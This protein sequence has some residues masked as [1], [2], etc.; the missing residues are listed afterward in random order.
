MKNNRAPLLLLVLA[1]VTAAYWNHFGNAFHFD[2]SHTI[3]ENAY[4]RDIRNIP[5]F[6]TDATRFSVLPA[7][8]SYRPV[9]TATLAIDYWLNYRLPI[10]G[11]HQFWFHLSTF[12][13]FLTQLIA[14]YVLFSKTM[15][16]VRPSSN[17]AYVAL[18]ATAWYGLHPAN[19]ETVNYII[20]RGDV[21][22]T[23]GV[24]V[25]LALFARFPRWRKTGLYL[26]P[27]AVAL[28]AK[29]PALVFPL[30]LSL[31]VWYFEETSSPKRL[32]NVL[33]QSWPAWVLAIALAWLQ[34][35]LTPKTFAPTGTSN[36]DYLITQPYVWL[37]YFKNFV[38]PLHLSADTELGAFHS[39]NS[40]VLTGFLFVATISVIV[41][42]TARRPRL[43]PISFGVA[44]FIVALLPTSVYSLSDAENDH[45]MYFAFVGLVLA[46]SWAAALAIETLSDRKE[47]SPAA[48]FPL[49]AVVPGV[50][51]VI[52]CASAY[53]THRR[54][55]VWHTER[56][57]WADVV[58]KS[59]RDPR[60]LMTY[61]VALMD[62]GE[63]RRGLAYMEQAELYNP[64]MPALQL[65]MGVLYMGLKEME[66]AG[67]RFQIAL[68]INPD[69]DRIHVHYAAWLAE[70]GYYPQ[71]L[72]H[73]KTAY[74]QNP[75]NTA[76][77]DDLIQMYM[78]VGDVNNARKVAEDTVH[79]F[80]EEPMASAFLAKPTVQDE[81]NW[82]KTSTTRHHLHFELAAL[83][84]ARRA[85][86]LNPSSADAYHC[87][88]EAY[89][90]ME[91]W[92]LAEASETK[93]LQLK[94]DF[95]AA[96]ANLDWIHSEGN[97]K[98]GVPELV[99]EKLVHDSGRLMQSDQF[100]DSV[101]AAQSALRVRPDDPD[102]YDA[103]SRAY[104]ALHKWDE[105][106]TAADTAL[107]LRPTDKTANQSLAWAMLSAQVEKQTSRQG[108]TQ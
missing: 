11:N 63:Y 103:L 38:L 35:A 56:S 55:A 104:A 62:D 74:R 4:I 43:R 60:G 25:G 96:K 80:P 34:S 6:F 94:P 79:K 46:A 101:A 30:L 106:K 3:V 69:D 2:D 37:R 22:S 89:A 33:R 86:K 23:A 58:E 9:V 47:G 1:A 73:L 28:L 87:M 32:L 26:L 48:G 50:A 20:Q 107:R 84:A 70:G 68:A 18:F 77:C 76:T 51:V 98:N 36:H 53:G 13:W 27:V 97:V 91:M 82:I 39:I 105:A 92:D 75:D 88:G 100:E 83:D 99:A 78:A 7:N 41:L 17:N 93:A 90:G 65:N 49:R 19:A 40:A 66:E 45:R 72:E 14:M 54:N 42:L 5:S 24:V 71:A 31:Y 16:A 44:W 15:E 12:L 102:A 10:R 85:L 67:R 61:G 95:E 21:Y 57:L 29:P 64:R 81:A 59:P 108:T 8:R 52:L